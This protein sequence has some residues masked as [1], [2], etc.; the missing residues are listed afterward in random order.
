MTTL[1][2]SFLISFGKERT[3]PSSKLRWSWNPRKKSKKNP[4]KHQLTAEGASS[5]RNR[6][7]SL[8]RLIK[9]VERS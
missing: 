7:L 4:H 2:A 3:V 8:S 9:Q 6:M 1:S 5:M